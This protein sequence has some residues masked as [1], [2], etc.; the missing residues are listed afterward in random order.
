ML[1]VS[2]LMGCSF[3]VKPVMLMLSRLNVSSKFP[4]LSLSKL[5]FV[6]AGSRKSSMS[7]RLHRFM[8]GSKILNADISFQ[9][10]T[11]LS[12]T[13]GMMVVAIGV[14]EVLVVCMGWAVDLEDLRMDLVA[15]E[16][17]SL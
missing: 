10:S 13:E 12:K 7:S 15:V 16:D 6:M 5:L 3:I 1:K 8:L 14:A 2:I 17:S 4:N 9:G 11:F